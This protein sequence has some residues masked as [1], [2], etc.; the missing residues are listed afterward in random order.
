MGTSAIVVDGV[1]QDTSASANSLSSTKKTSNST[2]D[3]DAFL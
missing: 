1:I 2:I 3:Q